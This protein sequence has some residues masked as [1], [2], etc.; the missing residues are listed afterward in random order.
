MIDITTRSPFL[1]DNLKPGNSYEVYLTAFNKYGISRG[2]SRVMFKTKTPEANEEVELQQS[3]SS[4]GYNETAC[5]ARAG[6]PDICLPLC[7]YHMKINDGLHLGPLCADHRT[8]RT[9][10][11][12]L[13][14]GGDHRPC[15]ERRGVKNECLH[16]CVG[17][18]N[19]SPFLIGSKCSKIS[20]KILQCMVEGADVLPGIILIAIFIIKY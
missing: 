13:A 9:M 10:V 19:Q 1:I 2:S 12:C 17:A 15:C 14:G 18:I 8:I 5:C 4:A 7:S 3:D 6:I 20:G 11:R 16:I